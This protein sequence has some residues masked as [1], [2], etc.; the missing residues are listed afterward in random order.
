MDAML[1]DLLSL[2]EDYF[3]VAPADEAQACRQLLERHLS[4]V[5][6]GMGADAA[7]KLRNA[8]AELGQW[9]RE[10]AFLQGL[11][12]GLALHRM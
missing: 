1:S 12:L 9:E 4:A 10:A 5:R 11:R 2:A 7:E 3:P 8:G 6:A